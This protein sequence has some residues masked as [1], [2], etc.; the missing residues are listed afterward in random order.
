MPRPIPFLDVP[1]LPLSEAVKDEIMI[2]QLHGIDL[3]PFARRFKDNERVHCIRLLLQGGLE[4]SDPILSDFSTTILR[5]LTEY[6]HTHTEFRIIL[7]KYVHPNNSL[8]VEE[9]TLVKVLQAYLK[10][11]SIYDYDFV[12]IHP[13]LVDT[14]VYAIRMNVDV[15]DLQEYAKTH[16]VEVVKLLINLRVAGVAIHSFLSGDWKTSQIYALISGSSIVEPSILIEEYDLDETFPE[17]SIREIIRAYEVDPALA[18]LISTKDQDG[19]PIYNQYQMYEIIEGIKLN[20]DVSSYYQPTL[21]D[22][23]MRLKRE[24]LIRK[25]EKRSGKLFKERRLSK[26]TIQLDDEQLNNIVHHAI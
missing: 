18:T 3:L 9:S 23:E 13:D 24:E 16:P 6:Q 15:Q 21:T 8:R 19:I 4:E 5:I 10:Y 26:S 20:L 25:E 17:G 2:A 22:L 7:N 11:G 14:F 12:E 1:K